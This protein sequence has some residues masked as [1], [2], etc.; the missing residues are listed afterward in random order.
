MGLSRNDVTFL[1]GR[2]VSQ[3]LMKSDWGEGGVTQKV[4]KSDR[5]EGGGLSALLSKPKVTSFL[6]SPLSGASYIVSVSVQ[7]MKVSVQEH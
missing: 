5:G 2:G 1:W 3:R 6:D 7:F 4:T